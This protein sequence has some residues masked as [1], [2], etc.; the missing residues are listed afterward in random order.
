M[1]LRILTGNKTERTVW[2]VFVV[3]ALSFAGYMV[4]R[5]VSKYLRYEVSHN[6]SRSITDKVF[7]PS[8]TF[9]LPEIKE[10]MELF[11]I[12]CVLPKRY[13]F[14][15]KSNGIFN[16]DVCSL[17]IPLFVEMTQYYGVKI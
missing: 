14:S 6:F 11:Q 3:L 5:Y 10:E 4:Y 17:G 1:V 9:C 15:T 16:I 13:I 7:Y 8:V 2:S 12:D